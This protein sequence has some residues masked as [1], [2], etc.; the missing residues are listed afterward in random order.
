MEAGR[1]Q[2]HAKPEDLPDRSKIN[3]SFRVK[4]MKCKHS[5]YFIQPFPEAVTSKISCK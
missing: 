1:Y 2:H 5:L 3:F 4:G